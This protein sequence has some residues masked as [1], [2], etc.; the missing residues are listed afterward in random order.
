V[1]LGRRH[2][3]RAGGRQPRGHALEQRQVVAVRQVLEELGAGH[4]VDP[5]RRAPLSGIRLV[6]AGAAPP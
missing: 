1:A 6:D 3:Q 5:M 2:H 4:D